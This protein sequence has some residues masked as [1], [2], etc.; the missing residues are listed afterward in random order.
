MA[1]QKSPTPQDPATLKLAT[2]KIAE[3]KIVRPANGKTIL[4]IVF[5]TLFT[6]GGFAGI[7][8]FVQGEK[9]RT[10]RD[11]Q[12]QM[13]LVV[14]TRAAAVEGWLSSQFDVLRGI[15]ANES[16]KIYIDTLL[17]DQAPA[18]KK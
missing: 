13:G 12:I 14:E 17:D 18:D 5:F 16:Q 9:E 3:E 11:W 10:L 8:T 4:A 2:P 7:L 6:I 15:A 1:S